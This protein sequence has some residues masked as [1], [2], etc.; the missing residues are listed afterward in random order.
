MYA[1]IC[2]IFLRISKHSD[3]LI[4]QRLFHISLK[5]WGRN[6]SIGRRSQWTRLQVKQNKWLTKKNKYISEESSLGDR[7]TCLLVVLQSGP[8]NQ[9]LWR[10]L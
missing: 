5:I 9:D 1:S 3:H 2:A 8:G 4:S 6:Y 7:E 10:N